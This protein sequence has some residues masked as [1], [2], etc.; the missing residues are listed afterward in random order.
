MRLLRGPVVA[1]VAAGLLWG[2]SFVVVKQ[3][4][5]S[6]DPYWFVFLRFATAA[7]I[8]TSY[9]ALTGRLRLVGRLLRDP[10]VV[11]LGVTNGI[12]FAM[13]FRGQ[14][15]T[16]AGK[17]ALFVNSSTILVA[18]ASRFVFRERFTPAK[19]AAVLVGMI[20]VFL[21]TTGGTLR[22][23]PGPELTGDAL[24]FA[25]AVI[26]TAFILLDKRIVGSG[27]VDVR[28]L[29]A[30]MVTVTA[31]TALPVAAALGRGWPQPLDS[32]LWV[33]A[34][35]AVFCTVLP[36]LLW[37][38]GLKSISATSS[39]VI[40]LVE[41]VFALVLAALVFGE[42]LAPGAMGGAALIMGAVLLVSR[43]P[44]P[45]APESTA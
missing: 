34:Y 33:V 18:I 35:T 10:L 15:L 7:V 12:G 32:R 44:R 20:G 1:T 28:A 4:L 17:A 37:S 22:F 5:R 31:L 41:V 43:E 38:W 16:T 29:T 45:A 19:T 24:V 25:A 23:T 6:I 36:F 2:S 39:C 8:A 42:R 30:A 26:W 27:D 3:G 21:V 9:A 11:W 40:L 14:V 13:Q